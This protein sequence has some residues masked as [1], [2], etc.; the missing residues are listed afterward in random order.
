ME[1]SQILATLKK[2]RELSPKRNFKQSI[3][4]TINLRQLDLKKPEHQVNM[5]ITLP[6]SMGKKISVCAFVDADLEPK[7]KEAC[8]E[9]ILLDQFA[10]FKTKSSIKKLAEKH[11]IFIAQASIMPKV[12][13][14]FGR[15]LG[16][17]GKMPNPKMGGVLPPNANIRQL[18]D[19]LQRTVSLVTKNEPT[20][21]CKAGSEDSHDEEVAENV[22]AIYKNVVSRLPNDVQNVKSALLKLTMGPAFAIGVSEEEKK[23]KKD[24]KKRHG[25]KPKSAKKKEGQTAPVQKEESKKSSKAGQ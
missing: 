8:D 3:D 14:V 5:F 15:Y 2:L 9:V 24:S 21:K 11:D 22:F 20:I 12:A 18:Y 23:E 1:K 25:A 4:L 6:H 19:G 16:P 10:K 13:T 7:A 17:R